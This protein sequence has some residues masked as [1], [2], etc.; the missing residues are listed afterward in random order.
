M[1]DLVAD[2]RVQKSDMETSTT[3][4]YLHV[5]LPSLQWGSGSQR[6]SDKRVP[7]YIKGYVRRFWQVRK[8]FHYD[9]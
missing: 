2:I 6:R 9:A 4:W 7:G 3:L 5:P 8:I 1:L